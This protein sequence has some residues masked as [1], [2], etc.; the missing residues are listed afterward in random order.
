MSNFYDELKKRESGGEDDPQ[1]AEN[2]LHYIGFYQMGEGAL[3]DAGYYKADGTQ[4]N[5]W[6]GQWTGKN[7]IN[8]KEDFLNNA[9]VQEIAVRE[10]HEKLWSYVQSKLKKDQVDINSYI[11]QTMN[12]DKITKESI[13]AGAHLVGAGGVALYLKTWG[14]TNP[15]DGNN[16]PVSK[17]IREFKDTTMPTNSFN[18]NAPT[19]TNFTS[20]FR[21]NSAQEILGFK[22]LL[23]NSL[24]NGFINS[25]DYAIFTKDITSYLSKN[26]PYIDANSNPTYQFSTTIYETASKLNTTVSKLEQSN[27]WLKSRNSDN[28]STIFKNSSNKS[29]LVKDNTGKSYTYTYNSSSDS[30]ENQTPIA[31]AQDAINFIANYQGSMSNLQDIQNAVKDA[32]ENY[33]LSKEYYD[34]FMASFNTYVAVHTQNNNVT[35][36]PTGN[37]TRI[38]KNA[39][40]YYNNINDTALSLANKTFKVL[41]SNNKA[42]SVQDLKLLDTNINLATKKILF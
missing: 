13:I 20:L 38:D 41:D 1:R 30:F 26:T 28:L 3:I 40:Y 42:L 37:S 17:Y 7:G 36:Q 27:P 2:S 33:G 16:V 32:Y 19:S 14:K 24:T 34:A 9:A 12:G 39:F 35:T 15:V 4:K 18:Y 29:L 22:D 23:N 11:G 6:K 25:I 5:D 31:T 10:Y 8:S 21:D